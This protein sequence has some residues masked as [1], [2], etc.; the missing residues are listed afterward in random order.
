MIHKKARIEYGPGSSGGG[1]FGPRNGPTGPPPQRASSSYQGGMQ[2]HPPHPP[3]PPPAAHASGSQRQPTGGDGTAGSRAAAERRAFRTPDQFERLSQIAADVRIDVRVEHLD[4]PEAIAG[5]IETHF[6]GLDGNTE[7]TCLHIVGDAHVANAIATDAA[8]QL[9]QNWAAVALGSLSAHCESLVSLTLERVPLHGPSPLASV[10]TLKRLRALRI[11][12]CPSLVPASLASLES[13]TDLQLVDLSDCPVEDFALGYFAGAQS[14]QTVVI[15]RTGCTDVSLLQ[16]IMFPHLWRLSAAGNEGI[17]DNGG[18]LVARRLPLT[19]LRLAGCVHLTEKTVEALRGY[20]RTLERLDLSGC[21]LDQACAAIAAWSNRRIFTYPNPDDFAPPP[22]TAKSAV[23]PLTAVVAAPTLGLSDAS[24]TAAAAAASVPAAATASQRHQA[25]MA[26]LA[27]RSA[28]TFAPT[29][30]PP[31]AP[32]PAPAPAAP[33]P[34]GAGAGAP[35]PFCAQLAQQLTAKRVNVQAY[36]Q[37]Q[38]RRG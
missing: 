4:S 36:T 20:A 11:R 38:F 31:P 37:N 8:A 5:W 6:R 30:A 1:S 13:C 26:A 9:C 27:A 32:A 19:H 33:W 21:N 34:A 16:T 15:D 25:A 23:A 18:L 7:I 3:H 22:P 28:P 10:G 24:A 29:F 14:L 2:P 17:T 12:K 35:N